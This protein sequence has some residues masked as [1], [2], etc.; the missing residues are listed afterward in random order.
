M[1]R[2]RSLQL[3]ARRRFNHRYV[4]TLDVPPLSAFVPRASLGALLALLAFAVTRAAAQT[5]QDCILLQVTTYQQT[6]ATAQ[7]VSGWFM[8]AEVDFASPPSE[9][10][11]VILEPPGGNPYPMT[12]N[13]DGSFTGAESF[14][15]SAAL[16]AAFPAG[17]YTVTVSAG[18]GAPVN[19]T[20]TFT[21]NYG[22]AIPPVLIT[23]FVALQSVPA[24]SVAVSW[25]AIPGATASDIVQVSVDDT[26]GNTLVQTSQS[27][28]GAGNAVLNLTTIPAGNSA[29]GT[30]L[31]AKA[32]TT[33]LGGVG[34][35]VGN[36]FGV[37]FPITFS[38]GVNVYSYPPFFSVQPVAMVAMAGSNATLSATVLGADSYQWTLNGNS[39]SGATSSS[40]T[41]TSVQAA[42]SGTYV[43]KATNTLGT[44][45]SVPVT[46]TV[47]DALAVT[48]LAGQPTAGGLDGNG[49]AAQ[50]GAPNGIAVD[51]SGNIYV[52]DTINDTI[53]R[54][55]P[56]GAVT[57]FAGALGIPG[58]AD[59]QGSAARFN[60]P[61]AVAVDAGGNVYVADT[62]N[63][64]VRQITPLGVTSTL[65]GTYAEP[66]AIAVDRSGNVFVACSND[67]TIREITPSGGLSILAGNPD[68]F[69]DTD[70]TGS[71]ATFR[72]PFLMTID[73]AGTLYVADLDPSKIRKITPDGVVTSIYAD[74]P[75]WFF[76]PI[77]AMT[78]DASGNFFFSDFWGQIVEGRTDGTA[79]ALAGNTEA[80]GAAPKDGTG[81]NAVFTQISGI[82]IGPGGVLYLSDMSAHTIRMATLVPGSVVSVPWQAQSQVIAQGGTAIFTAPLVQGTFQ[83]MQNGTQFPTVSGPTYI[84]SNAQA[85]NAGDYAVRVTTGPIETTTS[86]V[87]LSVSDTQDIG[88][89]IDVSVR[90][91]AGAGAQSLIAG[92]VVGGA[93]TS[94]S[95]NVLVRASGPAL[96]TFSVPDILPDP[97]LQLFET[98]PSAA[99]LMTNNG[100]GGSPAIAA[101]AAQVGAF[102]WSNAS[103]HDAALATGLSAGNYTAN[104]TGASGDS[105]AALAEVYDATPEGTYTPAT[106]RLVNVSARTTAGTGGATLIGGF[107]IGGST[108]K[109][110][111]IR[112]SGPA[113]ATFAISGFLTDPYL[114]LFG[115]S[116]QLIASNYG[117]GN[118]TNFYIANTASSVGAF[119]WTPNSPDSA[120]IVTLPPGAYTA[121]V[122]SGQGNTGIALIEVYELP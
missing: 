46:L 37:S 3:H 19:S 49:A 113:L 55:T 66:V 81:V 115:S 58:N 7:Q 53:R 54:V 77:T 34:I 33:D 23:D 105:G 65:P 85:S 78:V 2:V 11:T 91:S 87:T 94:G 82:A 30:L 106:P 45:Q 42:S 108:S 20:T 111:L 36:S 64:T 10:T 118:G 102:P 83:W 60:G 71:G 121:Q 100:W 62:G 17:T 51:S 96:A 73:T 90:A 70:G 84:V 74:Y 26:N 59:G 41:I 8:S 22:P 63:G 114:E 57:T 103:S 110:V 117:W 12:N 93:G 43:L 44:T 48:T 67:G 75:E 107:V 112:A 98:F 13:G 5:P 120:L 18:A 109:S 32:N 28:V 80:A 16:I 52:A 69:V 47:P 50:F 68:G 1:P 21:A 27:A 38:Q 97:Q 6:T 101:L 104:I 92:F 39:V 56:A 116:G 31:Y 9:T 119:P 79:V 86:S 25:A 88:R 76:F 122:T 24:E 15:S 14:S 35:I 99:L 89:L 61:T 4:Q 72:Y 29:I 40:Y 95:Q